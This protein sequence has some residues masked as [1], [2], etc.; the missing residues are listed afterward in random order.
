MP[1]SNQARVPQLLQP[2]PRARAGHTVPT[3]R[4]PPTAV[5]LCRLAH[6]QQQGPSAATNKQPSFKKHQEDLEKRTNNNEREDLREQK[7]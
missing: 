4:D 2:T 3:S 5:K 6:A 1:W 7:T